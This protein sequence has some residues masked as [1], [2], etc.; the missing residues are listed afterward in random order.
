[1]TKNNED[2][3]IITMNNISSQHYIGCCRI[4]TNRKTITRKYLFLTY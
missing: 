1:M 3:Q 4:K 2:I